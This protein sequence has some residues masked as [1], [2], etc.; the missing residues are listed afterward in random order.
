MPVGDERT[1]LSTDVTR[2]STGG[3][4]RVD[5]ADDLD[6]IK[7]FDAPQGKKSR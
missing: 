1:G 3:V 7:S 2:R 6:W 5:R 4:Y